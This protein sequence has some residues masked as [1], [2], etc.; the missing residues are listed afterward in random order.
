[1]SVGLLDGTCRITYEAR[2]VGLQSLSDPESILDLEA[3]A[4]TI[5]DFIGRHG[6]IRWVLA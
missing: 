2:L 4:Q 6:K 1:M 3:A 5:A